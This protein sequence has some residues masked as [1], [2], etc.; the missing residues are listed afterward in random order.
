MMTNTELEAT[1]ISKINEVY[2]PEIP[3]AVYSQLTLSY[4]ITKGTLICIP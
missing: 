3:V 1:I 4:T 2:D